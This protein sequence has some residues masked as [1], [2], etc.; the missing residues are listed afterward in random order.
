MA[1]LDQTLTGD[2]DEVVELAD[3]SPESLHEFLAARGWGDGLPV[4]APTP[5]RVERMLAACGADPDARVGVL[6]PRDGAATMRTVA[7]NAVLA[8]C[9]PDVLPVVAAAVR[10]LAHPE[11]NLRGVQATTHPVAPLVIVHG[12]VV[13]RGG[14][15]AAT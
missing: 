13:E 5:E 9:P 8:G 2:G 4:V 7:I 11:V 6:P 1:L 3:E 14:F 12:E 10:A 15:N